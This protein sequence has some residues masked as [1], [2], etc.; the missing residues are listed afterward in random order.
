MLLFG[1]EGSGDIGGDKLELW[2]AAAEG[3]NA[4]V[5]GSFG[6][7]WA[8]RGLAWAEARGGGAE[9]WASCCSGMNGT[10]GAISDFRISLTFH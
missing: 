5:G 1:V 2:R 4:G 9:M 3:M 10:I 6:L 8:P 7:G